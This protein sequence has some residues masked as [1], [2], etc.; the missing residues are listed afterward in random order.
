MVGQLADD[1][2]DFLPLDED[3]LRDAR[4]LDLGLCDEDGLIGEV[5]VDEYGS[6]PVILQ[7]ALHDMFLEVGIE[8]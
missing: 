7:S 4:V 8:A 2:G 6:D 3:A 5:V 1:L